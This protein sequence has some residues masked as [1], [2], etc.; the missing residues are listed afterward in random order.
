MKNIKDIVI[1]VKRNNKTNSNIPKLNN[2][3]PIFIFLN[4]YSISSILFFLSSLSFCKHDY[5]L[6]IKN[7]YKVR[8]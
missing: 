2:I 3:V 4:L 6:S 5:H 1:F 8:I 7:L